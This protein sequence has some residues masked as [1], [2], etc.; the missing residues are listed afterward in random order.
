MVVTPSRYTAVMR[1]Q[2]ESVSAWW[3]VVAGAIMGAGVAT[4]LGSKA[5]DEEGNETTLISKIFRKIPTGVK[6]AGGLGAL[7]GAG[8][9]AGRE[10]GETV[11][12]RFGR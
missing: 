8:R 12:E 10:I 4:L 3:Y 2:Q 1:N 6:V 7:R 9:E 11:Q 5:Y